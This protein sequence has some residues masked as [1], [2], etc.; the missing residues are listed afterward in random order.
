MDKDFE[1]YKQEAKDRLLKAIEEQEKL[2]KAKEEMIKQLQTDFDKIARFQSGNFIVNEYGRG[3]EPTYYLIVGMPIIEAGKIKIPI[4]HHIYPIFHVTSISLNMSGV[5]DMV[6][7]PLDKMDK[8]KIITAQE[9]F[10]LQKSKLKDDFE[11]S[12]PYNEKHIEN[13]KE[14]IKKLE[15]EIKYYKERDK[16]YKSIDF[17]SVYPECVEK[18]LKTDRY[19]DAVFKTKESDYCD[20]YRYNI[21]LNV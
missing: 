7:A 15:D 1:E 20:S 18:Y 21:V 10:E 16:E 11:K 17:D 12:I 3:V 2:I 13:C 19:N 14:K 4:R 8:I 9:Y 5:I 6:V